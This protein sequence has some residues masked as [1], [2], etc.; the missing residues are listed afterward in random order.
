MS[1]P[2]YDAYTAERLQYAEYEEALG[3][4]YS[5]WPPRNVPVPYQAPPP[6]D[7]DPDYEEKDEEE[8]EESEEELPKSRGKRKAKG[9]GKAKRKATQGSSLLDS[10]S[11]GSIED[12]ADEAIN[13]TQKDGNFFNCCNVQKIK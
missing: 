1:A 5:E 2:Q 13:P 4:P 11:L 3:A 9:K 12:E 6:T 7:V 8:D 10:I